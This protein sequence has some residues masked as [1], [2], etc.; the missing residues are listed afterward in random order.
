MTAAVAAGNP[1]T[2]RGIRPVEPHRDMAALA[3][4]IER[5]F[6]ERLDASGRRMI[7]GMKM[8]AQAGRLGWFLGRWFLP[9]AA[10]PQGFVWEEDGEVVGNAS[11]LPV[12]GFQQR[13]VMANVVVK[14][15]YQRRGI[16]RSL[17]LASINLV[18]RCGG[19]RIMLQV[20]RDNQAARTLY[21][22]LEF[23]TLATRTTWIRK[24]NREW[25]PATSHG[26]ARPRIISEWRE[27][28]ALA[29]RIHPEGLLWPF[30]TVASLFRPSGFEN[31]PGLAK[32]KHWVWQEAGRL[33]GMVSIRPELDRQ[34]TR[35]M[36]VVEPEWRGGVESS[37]LLNVMQESPALAGNIVMDYPADVAREKIIALGFNATRELTWM[38]MRL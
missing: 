2:R 36:M 30:P 37:L 5:A 6:S 17:V 8:F 11:L 25:S 1:A 21:E 19:R 7:L 27:Q 18:R 20:D 32:P 26:K 35:L 9:P 14:P 31:I 3:G 23:K 33:V 29:K 34:L 22:N 15:E 24:G 28:W 10:Y 13:W 12:R 38:G 16:A 4:L